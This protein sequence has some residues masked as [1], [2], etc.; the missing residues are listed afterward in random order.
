MVV[1]DANSIG[2]PERASLVR[3]L[4][5]RGARRV[6]KSSGISQVVVNGTTLYRDGK[7][8]GDF[9]GQGCARSPFI[10]NNSIKTNTYIMISIDERIEVP[11]SLET[12]WAILAD[13]HAVVECVEGAELGEQHEEDGSF[14]AK[15]AVKFGPAKIGFNANVLLNLDDAA[16]SGNVVARGK[17]RISGTKFQTTMHFKAER[18]DAPAAHPLSAILIKAE[19]EITGRLSSLI[20]TGANLVIKRMT[21]SFAEKLAERCGG[22]KVE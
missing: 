21:A 11:S 1:F 5:A 2:S 18:Q 17:D 16:K 9:P 22:A 6:A 15:M 12:V 13:P 3:D 8:S 20:E 14:D 10:K 19:C 4:P 7:H